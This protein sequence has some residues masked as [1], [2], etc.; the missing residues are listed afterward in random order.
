MLIIA[1][2]THLLAFGNLWI[3]AADCMNITEGPSATNV[4]QCPPSASSS[5]PTPHQTKGHSLSIYNIANGSI[6]DAV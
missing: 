4:R 6:L 5:I 1:V 3:G 2:V